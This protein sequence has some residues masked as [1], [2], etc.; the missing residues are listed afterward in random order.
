MPRLVL[1]LLPLA[2][3]L[4]LQPTARPGALCSA[5]RAGD[6]VAFFDLKKMIDPEDAM[7]RGVLQDELAGGDGSPRSL[8]RTKKQASEKK[9]APQAEFKMPEMPNPFGGFSVPNPFG[10]KK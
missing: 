6:I 2:S 3:A 8:A 10:D 7:G 1:L 4:V 9:A 5:A